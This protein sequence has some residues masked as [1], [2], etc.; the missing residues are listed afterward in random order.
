MGRLIL[1]RHGHTELNHAGEEERLRAWKDLSL[2]QKGLQEALDTAIRLAQHEV[3]RIYASDLRRGIQTAGML[4]ALTG[5]PVVP[6]RSLRPWNLGTLAGERVLDILPTLRALRQHPRMKAPG[7][8]S[9]DEFYARYSASLRRLLKVAERS[10]KTILV[11]THGRNFLATPIV[12]TR[13]DRTTIPDK[14]GPKTGALLFL[15]KNGHGWTIQHG[16]ETKD[17]GRLAVKL[18][19]ISRL[20][21]QRKAG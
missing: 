17:N 9:Y 14:G 21:A 16:V 20:E 2:D 11:V 1:V 4:S 3:E 6:T 7:G 13:G 18:F 5:A 15:E 19:A 10:S 12:L 8:E